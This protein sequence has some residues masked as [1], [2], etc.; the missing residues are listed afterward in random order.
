MKNKSLSLLLILSV[1]LFGCSITKYLEE[2]RSFYTGAEIKFNHPDSIK[3]SDDFKYDIDEVITTEPNSKSGAWFHFKG[4]GAKHP[5]GFRKWKAK[6]FGSKPVYY[7]KYITE[8]TTELIDNTL[9]NEGYFG[10]KVHYKEIVDKANKTVKVVYEID[11]NDAP[12]KLNSVDWEYSTD[13]VFSEKIKSIEEKSL[14]VEG[15]RYKLEDFREE[16]VRINNSLKDSGFYFFSSNYLMFDLDSAKGNRTVDVKAYF[17][18]MPDKVKRLYTIDTV[19]LQPDFDLDGLNVSKRNHK[20]VQID[21]G[22]IYKGDPVN[23]KPSI[24]ETTLQFRQGD[25]YSRHKHQ[26][27]L[28]QFSGLGVFKYVDIDFTP[29]PSDNPDYGTM[30]VNAKMSQVTLHSL[31]TELAVSTWSTGYTGPELDVTWKNRNTF[32]G[33][34]KLSFTVYTGI[35]KQFGGK[36]NGVD[37]I[38]WYGVDAKL[39]IPRVVAPFNVRPG[40]DFYIPYTNFG[41]G[42]KK[43]HFFPSYSLNYLTTSYGFDWRTNEAIKHTLDP[44]VISFQATSDTTNISQDIPSLTEAFRNQFILGSQYS[45]EYAPNW[46]KKVKNTSFYYKGDIAI[47]GNIWY[48]VMNGLGVPKN[49]ETG[50][51]EIFGNP[52]SQY[53]RLTNDFRF[54][55]KTSKKGEMATR[56]VVGYSKP[57]GNSTA[58]PFIQQYFV[59]GPNSIR[60]FRSRTLGPGSFDPPEANGTSENSTQSFGQQAGDIK[61]EG[62]FEYRYDLHQYL[63]L[64]AFVDY[65]NV[66][67]ANEDPDR[68]GGEFKFDNVLN[69]LALGAGVGLRIDLQ[70][71]VMRFDFAIPLRLPYVPEDGVQWVIKKPSFNQLVFNLAI[72]YPF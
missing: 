10:S 51:Y 15:E 72:G 6:T 48:A 34:E 25:I 52:Y 64:A 49:P 62:S 37:L 3:I 29:K 38:F 18:E 50:Q 11:I 60:A 13:G 9:D 12:Y 2:D 14:L 69:E 40:G 33:A 19:L 63:K 44:V 59:G 7:D 58:L 70:F 42:F 43:Y 4:E 53:V 8:K 68:P 45:F 27:T 65:G 26:A 23:L 24:L 61:I 32:G 30:N 28:R 22:I 55:F 66:W 39:S 54:Y 16:R 47:S 17:K 35:Q 36:T 41:V 67:L 71:F 1:S 20:T 5:K 31:S 46:N 21:S 57:W 56:F